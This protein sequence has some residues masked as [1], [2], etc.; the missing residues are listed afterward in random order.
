MIR[1]NR[2]IWKKKL[3]DSRAV[4]LQDL[5]AS[6]G[7]LLMMSYI[8]RHLALKHHARLV[9]YSSRW[10]EPNIKEDGTYAVMQSYG[11]SEFWYAWGNESG[12]AE[13]EKWI[14]SAREEIRTK[15]DL[16]NWQ[17]EGMAFGE[18]IY[19]T[20]LAYR[21]LATID[22]VNNLEWID[23]LDQALGIYQFWR[24]FFERFEIKAALVTQ[25]VYIRA[26]ILGRM[27][28]QRG[29]AVYTM[30]GN[31]LMRAD[32]PRIYGSFFSSSQR[33]FETL[34]ISEQEDALELAKSRLSERFDG[35]VG[36]DM[37]YS[38]ASAF[39]PSSGS[40]RVIRE[41]DRSKI[42]IFPHDFFDAPHAYGRLPFPDFYEWLT[43]LGKIARE[44]QYDWYIKTHPDPTELSLKVFDK[45]IKNFPEFC[46]LPKETSHH[47]IIEEG[48]DYVLTCFGTVGFEYPLF[49]VPVIQAS[50]INPTMDYRFT[51]VCQ[52]LEH[53]RE[54]LMNLDQAKVEFED[55]MVY[56]SYFMHYYYFHVN[57]LFVSDYH[58]MIEDLGGAGR[59]V[60]F[61]IY[62]QFLKE[63]SVKRHENT[64]T[65]LANFIDSNRQFLTMK[66]PQGNK[67]DL[68]E[69]AE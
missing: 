69:A 29:V 39:K 21:Q 16:M 58:K 18:D 3:P 62:S 19:E 41:S 59:K 22:I 50:R 31:M 30:D 43:F 53:Y 46:L 56:Q 67:I 28:L 47:Q 2:K 65:K 17:F 4:V 23:V 44:T 6:P 35:K 55:R 11:T 1:H 33:L 40:K 26:N 12:R 25:L 68:Q 66:G 34:S 13:R 7:Q 48:I 37:A 63:F 32:T 61:R 36:V 5:S 60:Y 20:C 57:D 9:A 64:R 51:Y 14:Q 15:N 27:A 24:D 38:S 45:I 52:D 10:S 54:T 8:G 42:I 49:R